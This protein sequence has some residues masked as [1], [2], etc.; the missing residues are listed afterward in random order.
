MMLRNLSR[1]AQRA[2]KRA[3]FPSARQF[4]VSPEQ[5]ETQREI[6][7]QFRLENHIADVLRAPTSSDGRAKLDMLYDQVKQDPNNLI[8]LLR[9]ATKTGPVLALQ[10]VDISAA[11]KKEPVRV[12]VTGAAGQIG[13]SLL[14]RIISGQMLGIDQPVILHL[15][16]RPEALKALEGVVMELQDCASPLLHGVVATADVNKAFDQIDY[17]LLVGSKPRGPG[18]ERADVLKDNAKIFS[19]QG[20]ALAANAKPSCLTLVVGNPANTNALIAATNA[21][22]KISAANFSAMTRL[23]QDRAMAQLALK[24]NTTI[25]DIDRVCIWGNHSATQYPDIN[26]ATVKGKSAIEAVNNDQN[27]IRSVFIP[28]VQNRGAEIIKARGVSSAASAADA[29][30][31]HMRDWALGSNTWVS[32]AVPTDGSYGV[33]KG[34]YSSFPVM[35]TGGGK[36]QIVKDLK[37]DVFTTEKI[38]AS[39]KELFGERDAVKSLL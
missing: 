27:W 11:F 31:K 10:N 4:S 36:Y 24:T 33:A 16:E 34:V 13:Y 1:T 25:G 15:L 28:T 12:A 37:Q 26:F 9:L 19:E 5:E 23:D 39:V 21:A 14:T 8:T 22:S 35:C 30:I 29:A 32:M 38:A 6:N 17:A 2:P 3:L 18:M 7:A 20:K